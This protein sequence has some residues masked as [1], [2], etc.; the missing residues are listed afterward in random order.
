MMLPEQAN[1]VSFRLSSTNNSTNKGL[2]AWRRRKLTHSMQTITRKIVQSSK[3]KKL[4]KTGN[5][6]SKENN[7]CGMKKQARNME[8]KKNQNSKMRNRIQVRIRISKNRQKDNKDV[9][10][11]LIIKNKHITTA[12]TP[13]NINLLK[14]E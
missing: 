5:E 1:K 7:E 13:A 2:S 11:G 12:E 8:V 6:N 14:V 10:S 9:T 3:G 4:R